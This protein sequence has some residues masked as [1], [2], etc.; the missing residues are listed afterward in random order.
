MTFAVVQPALAY[1]AVE[2]Q[3][4]YPCESV[5]SYPTNK[6]THD[7]VMTRWTTDA[8][9]KQNKWC[10]ANTQAP[11]PQKRPGTIVFLVHPTNRFVWAWYDTWQ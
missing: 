3:W 4:A 7:G 8:S 2:V 11:E 6:V 5:P 9:K 1:L 10:T